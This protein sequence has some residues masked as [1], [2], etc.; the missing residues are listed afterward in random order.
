[1]FKGE[2]HCGNIKVKIPNLTDTGTSCNCS[3]CS[4]YAA[5]WGYFKRSQVDIEIG[6]CGARVYSHGDKMINFIHCSNCGCITHYE[7]TVDGPDERVAVN[8]RMFNHSDLEKITIKIFD[9]ADTWQY[10]K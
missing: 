7:S 5:I 10:L 1:M 8:Y 2:C 4:K 6:K 9:G 3:I